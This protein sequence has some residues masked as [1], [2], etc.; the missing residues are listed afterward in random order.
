M[1]YESVKKVLFGNQKQANVQNEVVVNIIG[2]ALRIP[3]GASESGVHNCIINYLN[4]MQKDD[5]VVRLLV[6]E[7]S[8]KVISSGQPYEIKS[9]R[10]NDESP[11]RIFY[12]VGKAADVEPV[13]KPVVKTDDKG[14]ETKLSKAIKLRDKILNSAPASILAEFDGNEDLAAL[15]LYDAYR[16]ANP[17]Q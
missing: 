15:Y 4:S 10:P 12:A 16:R 13:Y 6:G 14:D 11:K 9:D 5:T 2:D 3:E 17:I 1:R 7:P 8:F